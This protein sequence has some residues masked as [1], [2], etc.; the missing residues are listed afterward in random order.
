[1]PL[2]SSV[3]IGGQLA[4]TLAS[5][6]LPGSGP[7]IS[8]LAAVFAAVKTYNEGNGHAPDYVPTR[9]EWDAFIADR[10]SKRIPGTPPG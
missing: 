2:D 10:E 6:Y 5:L 8:G 4:L 1:M 3:Q 7:A 9:E